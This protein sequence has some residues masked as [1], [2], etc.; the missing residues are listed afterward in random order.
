MKL[1][2]AERRRVGRA[3]R[4][5]RREQFE[6]AQAI[7]WRQVTA[8]LDAAAAVLVDVFERVAAAVASIDWPGLARAWAAEDERR[9]RDWM[10]THRALTTG[11]KEK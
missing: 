1:T 2:K 7:D 5:I 11:G 6:A 3:V 9:R 10:L 4:K 8:A